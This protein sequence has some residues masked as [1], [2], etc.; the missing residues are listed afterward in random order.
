MNKIKFELELPIHASPSMLYQYISTPSAL[1]EWFAEK[2]NSRGKIF[3]FI[4]DGVE[5]QAELVLKKSDERVRFKWLESEDED[6]YFEIKIQVHSLTN[7]V[8]LVV[9]D[10]VDDE[11]EIE[12]AKQL[13][14]NQIE[15]LKHVIGA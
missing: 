13:W 5:E 9:T 14:E 3:S 6:S 12:E 11:D 2:V 4:W 15:E 10:F 1:Q 7:D 8:S